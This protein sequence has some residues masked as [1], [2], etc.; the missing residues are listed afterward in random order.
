MRSRSLCK[1]LLAQGLSENHL[2]REG[3]GHTLKILMLS[4]NLLGLLWEF[5]SFIGERSQTSN[6]KTRSALLSWWTKNFGVWVAIAWLVL[7]LLALEICRLC[8]KMI[9]R[10]PKLPSLPFFKESC[11][12]MVSNAY[13]H[14]QCR[15]K[16]FSWM[17]PLI[18]GTWAKLINFTKRAP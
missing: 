7:Q 11:C 9:L 16:P 8:W 17:G 18:K 14:S 10:K 6:F 2:K 3:G 5:G 1:T 15:S 12:Q 13:F 4:P